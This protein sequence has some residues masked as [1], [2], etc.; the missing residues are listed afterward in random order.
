MDNLVHFSCRLKLQQHLSNA[1]AVELLVVQDPTYD[2]PSSVVAHLFVG[3][4]D[5]DV[6]TVLSASMNRNLA[7]ALPT[8][9]M[10]TDTDQPTYVRV[11]TLIENI[12]R[13]FKEMEQ[14]IRSQVKPRTAVHHASLRRRA[15][16]QLLQL[17]S[18]DDADDS[19]V[20]VSLN[21]SALPLCGNGICEFGE[22]TGTFAYPE[23]WFCS[24]DCPFVLH[25]CPQQV[26]TFDA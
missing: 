17:D 1:L 22:A 15:R 11:V 12:P 19:F 2:D 10:P 25:A 13:S 9:D 20:F 5:T 26:R 3:R 6:D 8:A 14:Q 4:P 24:E 23:A 16:R 21:T 18:N 7:V